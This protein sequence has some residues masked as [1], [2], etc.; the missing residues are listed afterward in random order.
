MS[1]SDHQV[2]APTATC[3]KVVKMASYFFKRFE[4]TPESASAAAELIRP[5]PGRRLRKSPRR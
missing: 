1:E 5:A 4:R 2:V 3:V